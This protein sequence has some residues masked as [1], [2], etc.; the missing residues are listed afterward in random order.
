MAGTPSEAPTS[1][2]MPSGRATT[3]S[4]GTTTYSCAVPVGRWCWDRKIQTAVADPQ[5][6]GEVGRVG[7]DG[8]DGAGAVLV[9]R[10]LRERQLL[11]GAAAGAGLPVG[12]VDA[13]DGD[14]DADLAGPG[15]GH[16][17]VD[18]LEDGRGHRWS[19]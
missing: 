4:T 1:N 19:V 8:V 6:R 18:E 16:L 7:A 9:R 3:C 13:G 11:A 17:A 14:L 2:E 10:D 5:P 12:G 15:L